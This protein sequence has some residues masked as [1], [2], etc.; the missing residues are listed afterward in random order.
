[1]HIFDFATLFDSCTDDKNN[2]KELF[3]FSTKVIRHTV[4]TSYCCDILFVTYI[5]IAFI[6]DHKLNLFY[7]KGKIVD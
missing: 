3:N 1:M 6:F 5:Y 4:K 2:L 7:F